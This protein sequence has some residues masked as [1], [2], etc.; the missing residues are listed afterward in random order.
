MLCADFMEILHTQRLILLPLTE[1]DATD[2]F[3]ARGDAEVMEFWD[4]PP[5]VTPSETTAIVDTLLS[6]VRSGAAKYWT[7]R[8]LHDGSFAGVCDLSEIQNRE[9]AEIGFMF[10]RMFWSMGFANEIVGCLLDYAKSLGLKRVTAR[11]HAGNIRSQRLLQRTGFRLVQ[12]LS[13]YEIRPGVFRDC[14]RFE[15]TLWELSHMSDRAQT[16]VW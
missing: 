2:L 12:L 6:D 1:A 14:L 10:L 13:K 9:S 15:A 7:I 4:G 3:R 5:D 8:L 11:I 16:E